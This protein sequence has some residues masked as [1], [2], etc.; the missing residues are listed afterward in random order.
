M[1]TIVR[2]F[3]FSAFFVL[4]TEDFVLRLFF[5]NE[6]MFSRLSERFVLE[7][8]LLFVFQRFLFVFDFGN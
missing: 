3:F 6:L 1:L 2:D 5:D 8:F 7:V 4:E